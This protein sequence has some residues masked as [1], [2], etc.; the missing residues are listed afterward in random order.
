MKAQDTEK[1]TE[2]SGKLFYVIFA[3][4]DLLHAMKKN[5]NCKFVFQH[6][7]SYAL[8]Q[9]RGMRYVRSPRKQIVQR[10]VCWVT[11]WPDRA[12]KNVFLELERLLCNDIFP[13]VTPGHCPLL[14]NT[15]IRDK[16]GSCRR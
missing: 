9:V 4:D 14:V 16:A 7:S 3:V 5:P 1:Q 11:G 2:F 10:C 6:L 15:E 13:P 12:K 8:S